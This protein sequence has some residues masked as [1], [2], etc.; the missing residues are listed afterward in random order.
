[1]NGNS[2]NVG[3]YVSYSSTNSNSEASTCSNI[4]IVQVYQS[5]VDNLTS[6]PP[7]I[8]IE[9]ALDGGFGLLWK[10]NDTSCS[11]CIQSGGQCGHDSI[12]NLFTC[13]CADQ[14]YSSVCNGTQSGTDKKKTK[15]LFELGVPTKY[16]DTKKDHELQVFNF[17][18]IVVA[19][20][21]FSDKNKLGEGGFGPVYKGN[22]PDG[23]VVAIKRLSRS[24]GQGL[25]EFKNEILLIVKLQHNNL[26]RLL[27]C[28]IEGDEKLL[29]YEYMPKKS[30]DSFLFG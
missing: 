10:T 23:Q 11:Q 19:T 20:N 2:S 5:A 15:I 18:S 14:P 21:N 27:G 30:L 29:I 4:T 17:Q 16:K 12:S 6:T 13:Y 28:S 3:Y 8:S 1:M 22:F 25:V 26:V 9:A 24:S 7:S